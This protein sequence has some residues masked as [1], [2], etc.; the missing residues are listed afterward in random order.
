[1]TRPGWYLNYKESS[2]RNLR[3]LRRQEPGPPVPCREEESK[4]NIVV[5]LKQILDPEVA[6]KDF[7]IDAAARRPAQGTAKL[8]MDSYA[9]YA[10][11]VAIQLKEK[12]GGKVTA[13]CAGDKPTDEVLRRALALTA[14]EAVRVWDPAWTDLDAPAVAHVL[15]HAIRKL[16]GADLVLVG[17]QAG[18]VERGLVGPLLAEELNAACTTNVARVEAAGDRVRL[19]REVDG[20][21]TVVESSLPAVATITNDETNV[22]RLPKVKDLMMATRKPI[23]LL[24]AGD[25]GLDAAAMAPGVA[26]QELFVPTLDAKCELIEG[27]DGVAKAINL[28][29]KLKDLKVL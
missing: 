7:K 8:V 21:F 5:C 15:A 19:R 29:N 13:L 9:E 10:L 20:G 23:A 25:L 11:E 2:L 16:G 26:L 4:L 17:R 3:V 6:P 28:T 18:D 24:G 1:M 12:T 27:D 22:P 14:D